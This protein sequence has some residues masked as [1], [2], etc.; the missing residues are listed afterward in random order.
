MVRQNPGNLA[1]RGSRILN[2]LGYDESVV[3]TYTP[4]TR[5]LAMSI[6]QELPNQ[7]YAPV[8]VPTTLHNANNQIF[9]HRNP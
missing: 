9:G 8:S 3:V 4:R 7:Q 5:N 2:G 1:K 6:R